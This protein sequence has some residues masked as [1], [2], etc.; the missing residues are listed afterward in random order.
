MKKTK[1]ILALA[2]AGGLAIT[3]ASAV[4]LAQPTSR[5]GAKTS[6]RGEQ[7]Q[8]QALY[9]KAKP[10]GG[11]LTVYIGGDAPGQWDFIAKAFAAQFPGVDVRFVTDLSKYHDARIDD[12]LDNHDLVADVA[13]LQTTQDF[14]RWKKQGDLLRYKPIGYDDIYA[15]SKD[16]DGYWTGAF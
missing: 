4:A 10:E 9:D 14:D 16:P 7:Q 11:K 12:Q 15:N 2:I 6:T 1:T 3:G 8:L 13:I 5:S